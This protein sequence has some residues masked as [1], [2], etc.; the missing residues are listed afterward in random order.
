[1]A[2]RVVHLR[3]NWP[4][5]VCLTTLDNVH[6]KPLPVQLSDK[7]EDP[8][9]D[10]DVVDGKDVYSGSHGQEAGGEVHIRIQQRNGRKSLTLV[11]GLPE[12]LNVKKVLQY[13]KHAFCCNGTIVDDS[14]WGKILQ[15]QGDQ[16]K[17][18]ADFLVAEKICEKDKIKVHGVL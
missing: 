2:K 8:F 18:I 13:F 17:N 7:E 6:K 14:S 10:I 9:R 11:Q 5:I 12:K 1:M 16:R 15:L 4:I 3:Y